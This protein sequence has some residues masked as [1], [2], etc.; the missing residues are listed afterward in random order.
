MNQRSQQ[1]IALIAALTLGLVVWISSV[2]E[3]EA[4]LLAMPL[5][6]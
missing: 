5:A 3:E 2:N 1:A 6:R 4:S